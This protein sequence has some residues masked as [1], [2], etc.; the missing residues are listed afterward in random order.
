MNS[1]I[2]SSG[3][4]ALFFLFKKIKLQSNV[5]F[6]PEFACS[7]VYSALISSGVEYQIYPLN[8]QYEISEKFLDYL[9][10]NKNFKN[11]YLLV[12]SNFGNSPFNKYS[13]SKFERLLSE[14]N[15]SI[16]EDYALNNLCEYHIDF[17]SIISGTYY[18]VH[19]FGYSKPTSLY[20]GGL[21]I[22]K[23]NLDFKPI[24][25]FNFK[26]NIEYL[27]LLIFTFLIRIIFPF[28][29]LV[30]I[31]KPKRFASIKNVKVQ[32]VIYVN[33]LLIKLISDK[34]SFRLFSKPSR[35]IRF[36]SYQNI[37]EFLTPLQIRKI[38]TLEDFYSHIH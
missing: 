6:V 15:I 16:V 31:L 9:L 8:L 3:T 36:N 10:A 14:T 18:R 5:I 12:I 35:Y 2:F 1:I 19:S 30:K 28:F 17:Q 34:L 13:Y 24:I 25:N 11:S 7:Q 20:S 32:K 37:H 22:S 21:I 26:D 29:I 27:F 33:Y 4:D 23:D 38:S